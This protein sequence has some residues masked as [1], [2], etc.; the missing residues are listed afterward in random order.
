MSRLRSILAKVGDTSQSKSFKSSDERPLLALE[1]QSGW[2]LSCRMMS[3][4]VFWRMKG[5]KEMPR[6]RGCIWKHSRL[7]RRWAGLLQRSC[8]NKEEMEQIFALNMTYN[9]DGYSGGGPKPQSAVRSEWS[10]RTWGRHNDSFWPCSTWW[11]DRALRVLETERWS[12]DT[13][14]KMPIWNK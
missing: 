2:A 12:D 3:A 9:N 1:V 13:I 10:C 8:T 5:S 14:K 11:C 4:G 7:R 6:K